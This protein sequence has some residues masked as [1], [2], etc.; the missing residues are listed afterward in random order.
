M[1]TDIT[2]PPTN[3]SSNHL[4]IVNH[5]SYIIYTNEFANNIYIIST[6][7]IINNALSASEL[8]K[9]LI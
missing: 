9:N 2:N 8:G 4:K 7:S 5:H 1:Y 6:K 3:Y